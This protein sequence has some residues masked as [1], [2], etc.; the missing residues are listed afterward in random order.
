MVGGRE[1]ER[2]HETL[3]FPSVRL[4]LEYRPATATPNMTCPS[5]EM[6]RQ[7]GVRET[8]PAVQDCTLYETASVQMHS[9]YCP[10]PFSQGQQCSRSQLDLKEGMLHH[11]A[12][13]AHDWSTALS[14][15]Q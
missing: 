3:I 8:Q 5:K 12:M 2:R 9:A 6:Y 1:N 15:K 4:L 7:L 10:R 11:A 14:R 13:I